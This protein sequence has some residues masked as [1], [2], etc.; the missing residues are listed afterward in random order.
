MGGTTWDGALDTLKFHIPMSDGREISR[1]L[2]FLSGLIYGC[3]VTVILFQEK[4]RI[5]IILQTM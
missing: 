4:H 3:E 2:L 1:K 5:V